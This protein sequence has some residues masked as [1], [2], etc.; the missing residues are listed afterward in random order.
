[1]YQYCEYKINK[2][3]FKMIGCEEIERIK[4]YKQKICSYKTIQQ[5]KTCYTEYKVSDMCAKYGNKHFRYYI[6]PDAYVCY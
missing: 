1:M 6:I 4:I 3:M 5:R 2:Y